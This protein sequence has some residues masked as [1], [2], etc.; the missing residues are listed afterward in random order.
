[1]TKSPVEKNG[2]YEVKIYNIGYKGK[3]VGRINNF[4]VFVPGAVPG[5][6]VKIQITQV[7]K[8]YAFGKLLEIL[9]S[10]GIRTNPRCRVFEKCGGCQLQHIDYTQQLVWKKKLVEDNI[11]RIGGFKGIKIHD[12][13]GM[14][15]PWRYRNKAQFQ[16]SEIGGRPVTGFYELRSYDIVDIPFCLIQYKANDVVTKIIRKHIERFNIPVYN[17]RT[18]KGLI[19][20]VVTR[21]GFSTGEVMVIVVINGENLPHLKEFVP[22]FDSWR[23]FLTI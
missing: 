12:C 9:K 6:I 2:V 1:M 3:G 14:E 8:N 21:T 22:E 16:V 7:K 10:S 19:R 11:E 17:Q 5:D 23:R 4:T 15:Y 20:H 18:G 13:I